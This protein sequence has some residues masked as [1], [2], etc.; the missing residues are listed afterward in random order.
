MISKE[1]KLKNIQELNRDILQRI[2]AND[3]LLIAIELIDPTLNSYLT[4]LIAAVNHK[5][6]VF[7]EKRNN[8]W[9]LVK[10]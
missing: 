6:V 5:D 9:C 10:C 2:V 8:E 7:T 3:E 1:E 4:L